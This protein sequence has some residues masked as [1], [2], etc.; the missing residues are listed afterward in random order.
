[1]LDALHMDLVQ[2]RVCHP[3]YILCLGLSV[4]TGGRVYEGRA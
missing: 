4:E 3:G 1:M 2:F